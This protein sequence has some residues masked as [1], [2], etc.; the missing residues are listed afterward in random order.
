MRRIG[1][2]LLAQAQDIHIDG[3]VRHRAIVSPNSVQKLFAAVDHARTGHQE[4]E[5]AK[6]GCGQRQLAAVQN[7]PATGAVQLQ[8]GG[9]DGAR[10]RSLRA[11]LI[12]DARHQLAYEERLHDVVVRAEFQA[13]NAIGFR[14]ARSQKDDRYVSQL[15]VIAQRFADL[16]AVGIRQHDVQNHQVGPLPP[17]QFHRASAGLRS[18]DNESFFFQV[19]FQQPQKV[20]IVFDE[21]Y[22]L[23]ADLF[24]RVAR[25]RLQPDYS[26][27][28]D[29]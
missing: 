9:A 22:F 6:F 12:L 25:S 11:E 14:H 5:Q 15:G 26:V 4:F 2:D 19:V 28:T 7:H 29:G 23:H 20:G 3:A 1:L 27:V 21:D 18:G 17:A 13:D 8:P 10:R 16:Q 24:Q